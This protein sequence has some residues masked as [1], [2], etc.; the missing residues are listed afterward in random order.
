M[1]TS[2]MQ[3]PN[4]FLA[5]LLVGTLFVSQCLATVEVEWAR[6]KAHEL[7]KL[8]N[9]NAVVII[10]IASIEQHGPHL[11]VMT[12]TRCGEAFAQGAARIAYDTRP[13]VVTPVVWSGLS[14]HHM[15]FGGTLILSHDTFRRVLADLITALVRHGFKDILISNSHGGNRIAMRQI[16]DE[17][18]PFSKA[19]LVATTYIMEAGSEASQLL[20]DQKNLMEHAGEGETSMMLACEPD[21]VD[22]SNLSELESPYWDKPFKFLTAGQ[23]SYRWRP[24][25]H[26]THNGVAGNPASSSAAKGEKLLEVGAMALAKMIMDPETWAAPDDLRAEETGGVPF[27]KKSS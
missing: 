3:L 18:A 2:R 21:L 20:E 6:L 10:P 16:L 13:T 9:E 19:T 12:D 23:N 22:V 15:Q 24:F 4:T 14:E 27:C 17:L 8:A 1:K 26:V 11:P 7:R 5:L 25:S